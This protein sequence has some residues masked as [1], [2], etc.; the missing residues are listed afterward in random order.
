MSVQKEFSMKLLIISAAVSLALPLMAQDQDLVFI[1][2]T[3][4]VIFDTR[5]LFGGAG[6]FA[7][8]EERSFEIDGTAANFPAQGGTAGGCGVPGWSGGQPVARAIFINY[9]AIEPQGG[10]TLKAWAFDKPEPAQGALVNY[11]ALTPPMN[12]SNGVITELRQNLEGFDIR[13]KAL[14]AGT[15][16]RGV[17]LGYFTKQHITGVIAGTGLSGGATA[18][19]VGL[20][21]PF[22]GVGLQQLSAAGST[23]G[24][25]LTSR[26]AQVVWE[27][28]RQ[29]TTGATG[30]TG[31][32]GSSGPLGLPPN[33]RGFTVTQLNAG[34]S[35]QSNS[36][37]IGVDGLA[38]LA[39]SHS[40]AGEFNLKVVHC[41][42]VACTV[43]TSAILDVGNVGSNP[44]V[45]IGADGL[46]LISYLD[47]ANAD[48]KVA[49]CSNLACTD[50]VITT[51]D[52]IG[53]V[54]AASSVAIGTD[55]L[56]LISYVGGGNLKVAH[57]SNLLCTAAT[58]SII[59]S[60]TTIG[61]NS[62]FI[63]IGVDGFGLISYFD[64]SNTNLKVAHC[65]SVLCTAATTAT[66]DNGA[67]VGTRSSI[68]IGSDGL[69]LISYFDQGNFD[70]KVAH[71][72]QIACSSALNSAF[73]TVGDVGSWSSVSVG[74]DGLGLIAY[75]DVTNSRVKIGHCTDISCT[76]GTKIPVTSGTNN[77]SLAMGADG[78]GL[79][80]VYDFATTPQLK[81][82]HLSH[83]L[84]I[85]FHRR[86]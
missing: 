57:C 84:G 66:I 43:S 75:S 26:G 83:P 10:G 63:A 22:A 35:D 62:T 41:S 59:D 3:P 29:G 64:F 56:A 53:A 30:V 2:V 77:V 4:C 13:V 76:T 49:H 50:A 36:I 85:P 60:T 55:G 24:Q 9:V 46:G 27:G 18:G 37:A 16:A 31:G 5:P 34:V 68:T 69:G 25:M 54:G 7:P 8:G 38:L 47:N 80:V 79:V 23:A 81:V 6:A 86:R 14:S 19:N 11:Q 71:C 78:L 65:S 51:V 39:M 48:L 28:P 45:A 1:S 21:I 74:P 58:L 17:I 12:N 44:S 15:H 42:N 20:D 40:D 82:A 72:V 32:T 73:D 61:G 33:R 70:L 67:N 52:S